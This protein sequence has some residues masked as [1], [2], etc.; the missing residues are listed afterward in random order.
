MSS[1][2]LYEN[3]ITGLICCVVCGKLQFFYI[4]VRDHS[5]PEYH[6]MKFLGP[7]E[8]RRH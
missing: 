4:S 8:N 2:S 3:V 5:A 6:M 7:V 1:K